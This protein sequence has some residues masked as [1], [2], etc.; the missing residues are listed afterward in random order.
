MVER[1]NLRSLLDAG[2]ALLI[3][4]APIHFA[5]LSAILETSIS[6]VPEAIKMNANFGAV[7]ARVEDPTVGDNTPFSRKG[8]A[9]RGQGASHPNEDCQWAHEQHNEEWSKNDPC[10]LS[11]HRS[12]P[13][14]LLLV[15][16]VDRVE[17]R[18]YRSYHPRLQKSS[19]FLI[20]TR[21]KES[22]QK[23]DNSPSCVEV[24][25]LPISNPTGRMMRPT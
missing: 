14:F 5:L 23:L 16:N 7:V 3:V 13:P 11:S 12:D 22:G 19:T 6:W 10:E 4:G 21:L 18:C 20:G 8:S 25:E 1:L 17:L 24:P 9:C 2:S 15:F